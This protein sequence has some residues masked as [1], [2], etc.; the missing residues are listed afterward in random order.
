ME[1]DFS[2]VRVGDEVAFY[3]SYSRVPKIVK[4]THVTPT[5]FSTNYYKWRKRGGSAIGGGPWGRPSIRAITPEILEEAERHRI[6]GWVKENTG[7]IGQ[8]PIED[9]RSIWSVVQ[10]NVTKEQSK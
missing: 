8:F 3:A 10:R 5:T 4:V 6:A 1:S 9:L 2:D 7:A